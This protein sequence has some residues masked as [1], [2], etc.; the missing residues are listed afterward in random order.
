M[1][2]WDADHLRFHSSIVSVSVLFLA[3]S[4]IVYGDGLREME[5]TVVWDDEKE[6]ERWMDGRDVEEGLAPWRTEPLSCDKKNN[7]S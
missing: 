7:P 4:A 5:E 1:L 6:Y 2:G 3:L